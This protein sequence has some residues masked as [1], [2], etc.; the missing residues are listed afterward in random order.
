[1]PRKV[2]GK[3]IHAAEGRRKNCA[4]RAGESADMKASRPPQ[5]SKTKQRSSAMSRIPFEKSF[6][7]LVC[8][9]AAPSPGKMCSDEAFQ[10]G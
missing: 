10:S 5:K 4:P 1:M 8:Q 6:M 3:T 7:L 2:V 9:P